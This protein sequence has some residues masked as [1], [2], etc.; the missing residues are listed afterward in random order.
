[1]K[2]LLRHYLP[3]GPRHNEETIGWAAGGAVA[4]VPLVR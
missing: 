4:S 2:Q 1:M 3:I